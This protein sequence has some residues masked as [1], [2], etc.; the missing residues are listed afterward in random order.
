MKFA[1]HTMGTPEKTVFEAIDL[2][3]ST[4]MDGIEFRIA[5]DG[6]LSAESFTEELGRQVREYAGERGLEI[7]GVDCYNQAFVEARNATVEGLKR[8]ADMAEVLGAK[9]V[10]IK[11]GTAFVP[12]GDVE[13]AR[14]FVAQALGEIG[15]YCRDRGL[16]G[17]IETHSGTLCCTASETAEMIARVDH[18]G[19][20]VIFDWAF[21][22]QAGQETAAEAVELL[23][24]HIVHVHAKDYRECGPDGS[25]G[26]NCP[27]G[28]GELGW[29]EVVR[30]LV[31]AGYEG[32]LSDEYEKY[33]KPNELPEPEE[34]FP[35]SL[36]AMK[37]LVR[38]AEAGN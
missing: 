10:R 6:V 21:I 36:A 18:P 25:C 35:R 14:S 11:A 19:L 31:Q 32:Y 2:I 28:E 8:T 23:G 7:V 13:L 9:V 27:L 3:A 5:E 16:V 20:G 15:A 24:P 34:W 29:Q 4:G 38:A 22:H 17:G 37:R 26:V 30:R 33:W 1:G 12:G